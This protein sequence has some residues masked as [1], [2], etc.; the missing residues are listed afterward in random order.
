MILVVYYLSF[1]SKRSVLIP[2]SMSVIGLVWT[3]GVMGILD[4]NLTILNIVTPCMVITLGSAYSIHVLSEYY[5][6][7]QKGE[8]KSPALAITKIVKT[9]IFACLTTVC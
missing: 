1:R 9:I 2:M 6:S 5:S 3:F 4:L 7:Y 8:G